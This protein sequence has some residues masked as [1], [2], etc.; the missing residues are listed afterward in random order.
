MSKKNRRSLLRT[1]RFESFEERLAFSAQAIAALAL[2]DDATAHVDGEPAGE[3]APIQHMNAPA[4]DPVRLEQLEAPTLEHLGDADFHLAATP[5]TQVSELEASAA[6]RSVHELTGV[7]VAHNLYGLSGAGQ[8]VAI[9]DS[10]VDYLHSAL[11]GGLGANHRVVGGY[12][13]DIRK[14]GNFIIFTFEF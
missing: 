10:G 8:T 7:N 2:Q 13:F 14:I 12:D 1:A 3:Y 6:L 11:G 9:I 4:I 5:I